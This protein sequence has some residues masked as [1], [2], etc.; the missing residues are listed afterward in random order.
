MSP[1]D[2][3]A[4]LNTD[5]IIVYMGEYEAREGKGCIILQDSAGPLLS[6]VA[7]GGQDLYWGRPG[8]IYNALADFVNMA[9]MSDTPRPPPLDDSAKRRLQCQFEEVILPW[10]RELT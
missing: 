1:Q 4:E 3:Q 5:V 6:R 7:V 10:Y 9:P 8:T 2:L